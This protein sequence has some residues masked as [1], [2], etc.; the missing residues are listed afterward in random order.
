VKKKRERERERER[1]K[2]EPKGGLGQRV[3]EKAQ[4]RDRVVSSS[5]E[6]DPWISMPCPFL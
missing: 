1:E 6:K 5:R 3:R 2:G 4:E